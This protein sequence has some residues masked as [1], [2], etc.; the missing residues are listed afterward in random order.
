MELFIEIALHK[1]VQCRQRC[2]IVELFGTID[3]DET[4][5]YKAQRQIP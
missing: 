3:Y 2:K 4:Y 5:S 1:Y